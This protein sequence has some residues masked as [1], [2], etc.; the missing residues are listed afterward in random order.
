M[1]KSKLLI[2]IFAVTTLF[3]NNIQELYEKASIYEKNGEF[4][5]AMQIYKQLAKNSLK[6]ET[7]NIKKNSLE[8]TL[9][10]KSF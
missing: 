10:K 9:V 4:K 3:G 2:V 5:K 8:D 7:L 6:N 1:R